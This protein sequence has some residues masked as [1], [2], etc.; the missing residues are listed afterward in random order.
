M[1]VL[2]INGNSLRAGIAMHAPGCLLNLISP[3]F[4]QCAQPVGAASRF[5]CS[6][7][8]TFEH[9]LHLSIKIR[10]SIR[11]WREVSVEC[12]GWEVGGG[13]GGG[14]RQQARQIE[15]RGKL[16]WGAWRWVEWMQESASRLSARSTSC[17]CLS[18]PLPLC[19]SPSL[20]RFSLAISLFCFASALTRIYFISFHLFQPARV[21]AKPETTQ[22]V[23]R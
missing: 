15:P 16:S 12:A 8:A 4:A 17:S 6:S 13:W 22:V 20:P 14:R 3:R 23:L 9:S 10:E 19:L 1:T 2:A 11:N 7:C 21:A 5:H 18:L